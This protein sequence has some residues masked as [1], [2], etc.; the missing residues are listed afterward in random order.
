MIGRVIDGL[1]LAASMQSDQDVS[2][3]GYVKYTFSWYDQANSM[4]LCLIFLAKQGKLQAWY[5]MLYYIILYVGSDQL[6]T[7]NFKYL[8][9]IILRQIIDLR[10]L[11]CNVHCRFMKAVEV[12]S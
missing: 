10:V 7:C 9:H 3:N 5:Y 8:L 11:C 12:V 2:V 6:L 4:R 1:P